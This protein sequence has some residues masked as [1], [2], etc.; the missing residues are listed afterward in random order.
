MTDPV[1]PRDDLP[2]PVAPSWLGEAGVRWLD[3]RAFSTMD[4]HHRRVGPLGPDV[5]IEGYVHR[6]H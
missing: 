5:L 6:P 3:G 4:L 1:D 2:S